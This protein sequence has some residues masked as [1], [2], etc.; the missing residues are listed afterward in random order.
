MSNNFDLV[1]HDCLKHRTGGDKGEV[2]SLTETFYFKRIRPARVSASYSAPFTEL[3][4][5]EQTHNS[6]PS[7]HTLQ[8]KRS[9]S[10]FFCSFKT[11]F[12]C[13]VFC[14]S[15]QVHSPRALCGSRSAVL[16]Q[17][18]CQVQEKHRGTSN[19][20]VYQSACL[21]QQCSVELR[22]RASL[23]LMEL[24]QLNLLLSISNYQDKP[25]LET[26]MQTA[27]FALLSPPHS[28]FFLLVSFLFLLACFSLPPCFL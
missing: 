9:S 27:L 7:V 4:K 24:Q 23:P 22:I 1:P 17:N 10:L 21:D 20:S 6:N 11:M 5:D 28:L 12:L 25:S 8:Q 19:W 26:G 18:L 2:N 14:S 13:F 3:E 15:L 16:H